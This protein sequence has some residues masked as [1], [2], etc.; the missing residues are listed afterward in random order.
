MTPSLQPLL[1]TTILRWGSRPRPRHAFQIQQYVF[2][3][4]KNKKN[5]FPYYTKSRSENR[6]ELLRRLSFPRKYMP[7]HSKIWWTIKR[8]PLLLKTLIVVGPRRMQTLPPPEKKG[9]AVK[10]RIG[11]LFYHLVTHPEIYELLGTTFEPWGVFYTNSGKSMR[12]TYSGNKAISYSSYTY[13]EKQNVSL[14]DVVVVLGPEW[15]SGTGIMCKR[16][17]ALEGAR[18][19]V[20]TGRYRT[21]HIRQVTFLLLLWSLK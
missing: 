14:G 11:R 10:S 5:D 3:G 15:D 20:T 16:V 9:V 8:T 12:P 4:T 1:Q 19:Y 6:K 17:A 21:Q 18:L 13:I 7:I 2:Y